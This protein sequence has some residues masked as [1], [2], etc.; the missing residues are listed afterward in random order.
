MIALQDDKMIKSAVVGSDNNL[1][2]ATLQVNIPTSLSLRKT[3][4]ENED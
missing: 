1:V 3:V 4:F 2:A